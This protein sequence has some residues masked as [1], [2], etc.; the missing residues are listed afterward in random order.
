MYTQL[1]KSTQST[2][3][4]FLHHFINHTISPASSLDIHPPLLP[5]TSLY[6]AH[7]LA[8][9]LSLWW[10]EGR[11]VCYQQGSRD[12]VLSH[13]VE[14][15]ASNSTDPILNDP[16]P[17]PSRPVPSRPV[18]SYHVPSRPVTSCPVPS[19][20]VPYATLCSP[21]RLRAQRLI[22]PILF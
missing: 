11:M 3:Q 22:R 8:P 2:Q 14:G 13:T 15:T 9:M 18:L 16:S 19:H 5:T 17:V 6:V 4:S 20:P 7:L 21:T 12:A 10:H 1:I